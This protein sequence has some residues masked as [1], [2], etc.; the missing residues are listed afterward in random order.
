M[1]NARECLKKYYIP[2]MHASL[3]SWNAEVIYQGV[4]LNNKVMQVT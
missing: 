1:I 4:R 3:T 2:Q